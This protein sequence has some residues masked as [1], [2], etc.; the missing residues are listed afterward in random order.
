MAPIKVTTI[1]WLE[2]AAAVVS[3]TAS[4]EELGLTDVNEYFWTDSKVILGYI[5][6]EARRFHTFMS[7]RIQ[8]IHLNSSPQQWRYVLTD[9]NPADIASRGS[10]VSEFLISSWFTGPQF[11]HEKEIPPAPDVNTE[12][13]IGDP[14]LKRIQTLNTQVWEQLSLSDRLSRF[15]S[16]SKAIQAVA[17]LICR[18][19]KDNS[20]DH[21]TVQ[22]RED[23][24]C[25]IIRD[26]QR[27]VYPEEIKL[28]SKVTQLPSQ[29]KL[30]QLDAFVDKDGLL[31][32]GGRLKN[33]SLPT[34]LNHPI[35]IPKSHHITKA[36]IAYCH[37][38][39]QHQGKGLT[40]NEIRSSGFWIPG[41]NR[42]VATHLHQCIT[43]R[44]L[45]RFT[46]EQR[47]AD[48]PSER[49]DPS[50]P[51]TYCRMDCFGPFLT[52]QRRKVKKKV[53]SAFHLPLLSSYP[54]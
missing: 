54:H 28:L 23:T 48:L 3:A 4:K 39:V 53:W 42:A 50:P 26:L 47:M 40:I 21:S 35:I 11:L 29:S 15:S 6:N 27:Q 37:E 12:I 24:H 34:S 2:L 52:K 19:R 7:N 45:R 13:Q 32:V 22:E 8:K 16:W 38:K 51:F 31:K 18:A 14:E 1:P 5:N 25:I 44:K 30:F 20:T 17:R 46:E 36:I 9:D 10:C 41:I 49:V 33:A 43:C